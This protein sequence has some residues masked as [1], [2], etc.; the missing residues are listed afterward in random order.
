MTD[1]RRF[2]KRR[3]VV[4][5]TAAACLS[6]VSA[7]IL[8]VPAFAETVAAKTARSTP[9]VDGTPCTITARACVDLESSRAWLID[10]GKIFKG[11]VDVSSGGKG[12]ETPT[13]HSLRVYRK[14]QDHKS[15]ESRQP[16]GQPSDMPWSVFFED[17]GIAFHG[18]DP[19]RASAG[20]IHLEPSDAKIWYDHLQI[21]D[22]VQVVYA[23]EEYKAHNHDGDDDEALR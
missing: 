8:A 3:I 22:Q 12:K 11:P 4:V 10:D 13:G 1:G 16:N 15:T 14:E 5:A 9:L 17:G 21:G 23:S 20:C 19:E 6:V 18:G 7:G 2:G